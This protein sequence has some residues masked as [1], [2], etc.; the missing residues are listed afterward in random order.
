MSEKTNRA[1]RENC[2][3]GKV[4]EQ[5]PF[6]RV[7]FPS[8]RRQLPPRTE[9]A[10]QWALVAARCVSALVSPIIIAEGDKR[11]ARLPPVERPAVCYQLWLLYWP[12]ELA[13]ALSILSGVAHY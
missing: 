1:A 9:E 11:V 2:D 8:Q 3:A 7:R 4:I 10:G 13:A 6:S 5:L 12:S